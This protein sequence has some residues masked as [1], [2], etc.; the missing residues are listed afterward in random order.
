MLMRINKFYYGKQILVTGGAG[1]IGSHLVEYLVRS[2][3]IVTVLDNLSRGSLDKIKSVKKEINFINVD[4]RAQVSLG[5]VFSKQKIIFN[6]AAFNTG[7]DY[8][9]GRTQKMFEEN[10]LLQMLPLQ[11][12]FQNNVEKFIQISSASVYS[13]EAMEKR[14]PI[15]E[16]DD[17]GEPE[18][19]K[20][21]YAMAKKMGEYLAKWYSLN[22]PLHTV[23]TRFINVYGTRDNYDDKCHFIPSIINKFSYSQKEI[24]VFGSGNQ[25]RSFI[26]VDDVVDALSILGE[27][28]KRAE[29]YNVDSQDEHSVK[30]IVRAIQKKMNRKDVFVKY[31]IT[32]PEGSKRRIL[33]NNKLLALGWKPT[34][35]LMNSLDE[36]IEDHATHNSKKS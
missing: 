34:K 31:D 2:G 16:D 36:L 32:K 13:R 21:G 10:M 20:L 14:N 30:F 23:I 6:L 24:V 12:A 29:V 9:V 27:K 26:H 22:S 8:D 3:A 1:F 5:K 19:S 17:K 15:K 28:G 11:A 33:D 18:P 7:I 4:L 35:K 25:K